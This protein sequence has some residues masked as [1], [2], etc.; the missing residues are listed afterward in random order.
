[1]INILIRKVNRV[2][3]FCGEAC[4]VKPISIPSSHD[5]RV[6]RALADHVAVMHHGRIIG[7]GTA[8]EIFNSPVQEYI[9]TPFTA[10]LG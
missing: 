3:C 8:P 10:A 4:H 6:V 9:R 2:M 1:V 5:L 7:A